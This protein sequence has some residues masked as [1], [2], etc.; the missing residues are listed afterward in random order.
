[1]KKSNS[2]AD[3][4]ELMSGNLPLGP[5]KRESPKPALKSVAQRT[6]SDNED[7]VFH[8]YVATIINRSELF[9][10]MFDSEINGASFANLCDSLD[11]DLEKDIVKYFACRFYEGEY[12]E[13]DRFANDCSNGIEK[14]PE[15]HANILGHILSLTNSEVII[16]A[17]GLYETALAIDKRLGDTSKTAK[18]QKEVKK[19]VE[20]E[21]GISVIK[22][23][24]TPVL[25][26]PNT[27][28]KEKKT[29]A[30]KEITAKKSD[31]DIYK[32]PIWN[33][34]NSWFPE[35]DIPEIIHGH[36]SRK[37]YAEVLKFFRTEKSRYEG[38]VSM[39]N[40]AASEDYFRSL[41]IKPKVRGGI[42][43]SPSIK[44]QSFAV[45]VANSGVWG[46]IAA[47]GGI[48]GPMI[49]INAGHG[50]R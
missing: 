31:S 39:E 49:Y 18:G 19:E 46:K 23:V 42:I 5:S 43:S 3:L 38:I 33:K 40:W 15:G 30:G 14:Q 20:K 28:K 27:A 16:I 12:S 29:S 10:M 45:H 25:D 36:Y 6:K 2:F 1:M 50:R 24:P 44:R 17:K 35:T 26:K 8:E 9:E 22:D 32:A 11:N 7:G 47:Y 21:K 4:K 41:I 34:L 37:E 48:N 13:M